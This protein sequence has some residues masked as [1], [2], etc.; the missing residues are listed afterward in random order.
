MPNT[1]HI[2][3]RDVDFVL[4]EQLKVQDLQK[5]SKYEDFGQED[6]SMMLDEAQKFA[7]D[8]TAPLNQDGDRIGA[9]FKDGEVTTPPG[10]K[11][12]FAAAA[13]GGWVGPTMSP[14]YGGMGLP[15]IIGVTM[16]EMFLA[17]NTSFHLNM[18]LSTGVG[19][20]VEAFG[21]EEQKALFIEKLYTGIWAGTMVLT[22]PGAGSALGD[23][24]TTATKVEGEDYYLVE[25]T[26]CFIT[27]GEHDLT[28]NIIH[29]VLAK[30]PGGPGGTKD[31]G[32]FL[33][34]KFD[35][36]D[37]GNLG[38]RNDVVCG[39]IE[40]KMGIHGSPT[41]ILNFGENGACKGWLI[42]TAE[43]QG[44]RMMF[45]MMNE[46]RLMTGMQGVALT[47][48]AY[49]NAKR[50]AKERLQGPDIKE[51]KN[52]GAKS[53]AIIKHAD[54]R[55]MLMRQKAY[56]EGMRAFAYETAL[57]ADLAHVLEDETEAA[58][59]QAR[60]ALLTPL[61]KAFCTDKGVEMTNEAIQCFGGYGFCGEYP[62]E[63]YARDA[64]IAPLYEGTNFIQSADLVGRKLMLN[65]GATYQ[66]LLG[67]IGA[68]VEAHK[69][70]EGLEDIVGAVG[71]AQGSLMGATGELLKFQ[72][73]GNYEMVMFMAT[74]FLHL[75]AEVM[76]GWSLAKQAVL[77][78][79]S[80]EGASVGDAS[81][82][83][84]KIL[85]ARFF[86]LNELPGT[87]MKLAAMQAADTSAMDMDEEAF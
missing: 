8:V 85:T 84:G 46:A 17:A 40:H 50:Y 65:G 82:Y 19:H 86:A 78:Q 3:R 71:K 80:I 83:R 53:V 59:A 73:S 31:L 27:A 64:R 38:D 55:R 77:A 44:M 54:V 47:G 11:E 16:T 62:V 63:Q 13:E 41:C 28:E 70:D 76:V 18:G 12:A 32:L 43:F 9:Q 33:V 4:F 30:I 67:E 66:A 10:F 58:N 39:G 79:A 24:R 34:P 23:I 2:N 26:K 25:G 68:W 20:M 72:G 74:R 48:V 1:F 14:E 5:F 22:E 81:F 75:F 60:L 15:E 87:R 42:G 45:Q 7:H 49:E 37:A 61:V 69:A 51:M 36:D 6:Y 29:A 52:R 56:S 21:T 57:S 35:V